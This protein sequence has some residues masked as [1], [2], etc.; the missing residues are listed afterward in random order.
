MSQVTRLFGLLAF[1]LLWSHLASAGVIATNQQWTL[2]SATVI[3]YVHYG[4]WIA[5]RPFTHE[6]GVAIGR[7]VRADFDSNPE[8]VL[9]YREVVANYHELLKLEGTS[10][11]TKQLELMWAVQYLRS[12]GVQSAGGQALYDAIVQQASPQLKQASI[13]YMQQV[14]RNNAAILK[15]QGD[16]YGQINRN[17]TDSMDHMMREQREFYHMFY[18]PE[19]A[20]CWTEER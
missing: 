5:G 14:K 4:E 17:F 11:T 10:R 3:G 9:E 2:D 13:Q 15:I 18:C 1:A 8:S 12:Q 6:Q 19:D 20:V 16:F 7:G